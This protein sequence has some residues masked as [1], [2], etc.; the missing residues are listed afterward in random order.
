ML[1]HEA[2]HLPAARRAADLNRSRSTIIIK[3]EIKV[4]CTRRRATARREGGRL[5]NSAID[6]GVAPARCGVK[7]GRMTSYRIRALHATRASQILAD[8]ANSC[9][10]G[11]FGP[12]SHRILGRI[13]QK[14][15][16]AQEEG[17]PAAGNHF[18]LS[19]IAV[20][21]APS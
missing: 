17:A 6:Q 20:E 3:S 13:R 4:R 15:S 21:I 8:A 7:K 14:G 1:T 11:N 10:A 19:R 5:W 9:G 12:N 16:R 2:K 18:Y